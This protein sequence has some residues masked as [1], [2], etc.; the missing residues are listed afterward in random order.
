[1]LGVG[2]GGVLHSSANVRQPER[3]SFDF[4]TGQNIPGRFAQYKIDCDGLRFA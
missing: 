2:D 3:K 4:Q 1:M